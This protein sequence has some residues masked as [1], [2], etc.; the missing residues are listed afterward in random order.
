[1]SHHTSDPV[2]PLCEEKLAQA[3]AALQSWFREKIK[4]GFPDAHISWSF[5]NQA[6]QE[7]A[8]ADGKT[9]AH[10]PNSKHNHM[11]SLA[12]DL[13]QIDE[14]GK[15]LWSPKF[16]FEVDEVT[17]RSGSPIRWGGTFRT[18]GDKDHFELV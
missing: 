16:F 15:A 9:K 5:R 11:P 6:D 2:C 8:Y 13:F 1:M 4:P 14:D 3:D 12:L 10:W 7:Q 18:I 17:Q